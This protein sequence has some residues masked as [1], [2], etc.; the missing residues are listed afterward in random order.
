MNG[1]RITDFKL[2]STHCT[3]WHIF[4]KFLMLS[5][6]S[7]EAVNTTVKNMEFTVV[8]TVSSDTCE[9]SSYYKSKDAN[10]VVICF[11]LGD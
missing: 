9:P 3:K 2:Q 4:F 1:D 8:F 11:T 10:L 7:D 6:T 5:D